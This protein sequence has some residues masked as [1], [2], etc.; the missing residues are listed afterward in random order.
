MPRR[1]EGTWHHFHSVDS[2][3]GGRSTLANFRK[4][5]PDAPI[6][7]LATHGV[8][9]HENPMA[10]ALALSDAPINLHELYDLSLS[11][12]LVVLSGCQTG[13]SRIA[14]GEEMTGLSRGFLQSGVR[15]MIV[16]LWSVADRSTAVFMERL[17]ESFSKAGGEARPSAILR[18]TMLEQRGEFRHPYHWAPFIMTGAD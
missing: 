8:L 14:A 2:F 15:A 5:A 12:R 13:L 6:I 10:S 7:H 16:S 1:S 17:Y 3:I 11:A 4:H 9:S 18:E